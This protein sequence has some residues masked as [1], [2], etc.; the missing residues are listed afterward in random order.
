MPPRQRALPTDFDSRL[1]RLVAADGRQSLAGMSRVGSGRGKGR[2]NESVLA[3]VA[4]VDDPDG[5]GQML[6][7]SGTA[8]SVASGG[9]YLAFGAEVYRHG[10]G[11]F[12]VDAKTVRW[13]ISV[14][15]SIQVEFAWA[16]YTGGGTVEIEVDGVVPA[17]GRIAASGQGQYLCKRRSVKIDAGSLVKIKMTH[18]AG[19]ALTAEFWVEFS[20]DGPVVDDSLIQTVWLDTAVLPNTV[21]SS[22]ALKLG[23]TYRVRVEGNAD[24]DTTLVNDTGSPDGVIFPSPGLGASVDAHVDAETWYAKRAA[25]DPNPV[26]HHYAWFTIDTGSGATH[27]EPEGGPYSSP[28]SGHIYYYR[29]TGRGVPVTFA[30]NETVALNNGRLRIDIHRAD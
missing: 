23:G 22:V 1:A 15:G 17:W 11:D 25:N 13:P 12:Y 28:R 4:P 30:T 9:D 8:A 20:V 3:D 5:Q 18:T 21:T 10:F 26:P 6:V 7:L 16:S 24:L 19:S 29:I 2:G 14:K 27:V